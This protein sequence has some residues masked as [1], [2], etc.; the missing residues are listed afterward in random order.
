M[1]S[2]VKS[3]C[4]RL[5]PK[6]DK[7]VKA[8]K[9]VAEDENAMVEEEIEVYKDK[10]AIAD[11]ILKIQKKQEEE[12][13]LGAAE[14]MKHLQKEL[15]Q[16]RKDLRGALILEKT[17]VQ[18]ALRSYRDVQLSVERRNAIDTLGWLED[19]WFDQRKKLDE[20]IS[21][22]YHSRKEMEDSETLIV[23]LEHFPKPGSLA[24]EKVCMARIVSLEMMIQS[25]LVKKE[26]VEILLAKYM[27][28]KEIITRESGNYDKMLMDAENEMHYQKSEL[29]RMENAQD[30]SQEQKELEE[31]EMEIAQK[32]ATNG[33]KE[34]SKIMNSK[35][36]AMEKKKPPQKKKSDR[37]S[38]RI[39]LPYDQSNSSRNE[40]EEVTKIKRRIETKKMIM[41]QYD[42]ITECLT[43]AAHVRKIEDVPDRFEFLLQMRKRLADERDMKSE[44]S[45]LMLRQK[46][47]LFMIREY[48]L[49]S[50]DDKRKK[51]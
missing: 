11:E 1:I 2:R 14:Q 39:K 4:E 20:L 37:S 45:K 28:I 36:E 43:N 8:D 3:P 12:T 15:F 35:R 6:P 10:I 5:I 19:R 9:N 48:L 25:M 17:I 49:S 13:R 50:G 21:V 23:V 22:I 16:L 32:E 33:H 26:T 31:L 34:R 30:F 47:Q 7:V 51:G 18:K 24:W 44:L 29:K 41:D 42:A 40:S 46:E 27:E 38:R